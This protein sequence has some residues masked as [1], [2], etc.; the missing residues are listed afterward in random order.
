MASSNAELIANSICLELAVPRWAALL[1]FLIG[2]LCGNLALAQASPAYAGL[3]A[4]L[5]RSMDSN[6][7]NLL[8]GPSFVVTD[9][10]IGDPQVGGLE[11]SRSFNTVHGGL[12]GSWTV[13][14]GS[15]QV[16]GTN[17]WVAEDYSA[18]LGYGVT[19][20]HGSQVFE[21]TGGAEAGGT[22]ISQAAN[23]E[24]LEIDIFNNQ[25]TDRSRFSFYKRD[26]SRLVFERRLL[27]SV[28]KPNGIVITYNYASVLD[29]GYTREIL[30]SV[31]SNAGYMLHF[32]YGSPGTGLRYEV[33]EHSFE[34]TKVVGINTRIYPCDPLAVICADAFNGVTWPSVTFR[35]ESAGLMLVGSYSD[36]RLTKFR[37]EYSNTAT[38]MP[39]SWAK[40]ELS[41]QSAAGNSISIGSYQATRFT[42]YIQ[43]SQVSRNGSF[44]YRF[45]TQGGGQNG[46]IEP[47][48]II[49]GSVTGPASYTSSWTTDQ[50]CQFTVFGICSPDLL[51][52][53]T[54]N[55]R[56]TRYAYG[57]AN[58]E[59][60]MTDWNPKRLI[61]VTQH[62]GDYTDVQYD[63]R[64]NILKL[65]KTPKPGSGL[66]VIVETA[67]YPEVGSL[68]CVNRK[69]CNQPISTRDAAGNQTDYVY[70]AARGDLLS[71]IAPAPGGTGP[72]A[73]VRPTTN[74]SYENVG[75]SG[76]WK[77]KTTSIC[78]IAATC[79]GSASNSVVQFN[80]NHPNYL[81]SDETKSSGDGAI[82][83]T[84]ALTYTA[85]GDLESTDGPLPGTFDKSWAFYDVMRRK[86]AT[87]GP[88]PDEGGPLLPRAQ[89]LTLNAAGLVTLTDIGTVASP[90][91]WA[92][93]TVLKR[94]ET[95]YDSYGRK[96]RQLVRDYTLAG[97]AIQRATN[98]SYDGA[99][100]VQCE[101]NRMNSASFL[102]AVSACVQ[103]T[104]NPSFGPDRIT[105]TSY[106]ANGDISK[107]EEGLGTALVRNARVITYLAPGLVS[108]ISDANGNRTTYSY[109]GFNRLVKTRY[110]SPTTAGTSS[111]TD[112]EVHPLFGPVGA[113]VSRPKS[114]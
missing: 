80:Y 23:G 65:I 22:Y 45:D 47:L 14:P 15:E 98:W 50:Q 63:K 105:R 82:T 28:E 107:I 51:S 57:C 58:P 101:A 3:H 13:S 53:V 97:G 55:G 112:Y 43:T 76:I 93:L 24:T 16:V 29:S 70:E 44:N 68:L 96:T 10:T 72:Y 42:N 87:V 69:T 40:A 56:T 27:R 86:V 35:R 92:S 106:T 30:R 6:N 41:I 73:T 48:R 46:I 7:V 18:Y 9:V 78:A 5:V 1:A 59:C 67:V 4:P 25:F 8:A 61:R 11:F 75:G 81:L 26:G 109:D 89:K 111:T 52:T 32:Q 103:T 12:F 91:N 39:G 62:D 90:Q 37:S 84:T 21:L 74:Y 66:A 20:G 31:T 102:Q 77:L 49:G 34:I 54:V 2:V 108:T 88:D 85:L 38:Y 99:G 110:P 64:G 19:Y 83:A 95:A 79:S 60:M 100:R 33:S 71:K 36:G 104:Q 17:G 94:E 113:R 114:R